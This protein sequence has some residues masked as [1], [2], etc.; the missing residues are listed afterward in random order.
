MDHKSIVFGSSSH[1]L[2]GILDSDNSSVDSSDFRGSLNLSPLRSLSRSISKD[3]DSSYTVVLSNNTISSRALVNKIRASNVD[4]YDIEYT[5]D[6]E[7]NDLIKMSKNP[8]W[9]V[10]K[11]G[12]T[13]TIKRMV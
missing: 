13:L 2:D 4:I 10:S 11:S 9:G 1:A 6:L 5:D 8:L 12:N 7:D 3:S